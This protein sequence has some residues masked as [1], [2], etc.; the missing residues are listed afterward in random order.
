MDLRKTLFVS[1]LVWLLAPTIAAA[2]TA[3]RAVV[4]NDQRFYREARV[5]SKAVGRL[6]V[7]EEVTVTG[8]QGELL[9]ISLPNQKTGWTLANGL[10]VLDDNPHAPAL[11]FEAAD[12]MAQSD[13]IESWQAAARLFRK[14]A[15]LSCPADRP[16][17]AA[18]GAQSGKPQAAHANGCGPLYAAEASWRAA[19][20]AYQAELRQTGTPSDKGSLA[21]L[22]AVTQ[23]Y[24]K[25]PAAARAAFLL[26]RNSLCDSWDGTPGCPE[27][28]IGLISNFLAR[29]PDSAQAV[30]ARYAIAYRHAALVEIYLAKDQPH[31]SPEKAVEHK[32]TAV[33]AAEA[34]AGEAA[35]PLWNARAE[36]L[37]WSLQNNVGVY[38]AI[39]VALKKQ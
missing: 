21:D 23:T 9:E 7:G 12:S 13:T 25:T 11:L 24:S 6:T 8:R 20:L 17:A 5:Q 15:A 14:A 22:A 16:P 18:A 34:V 33:A 1:L 26:L 39:E 27:A 37:A 35:G 36:R 31:F 32:A 28:E 2:A 29:Y 38:S 3:H 19:E 30:E 4:T 10:V